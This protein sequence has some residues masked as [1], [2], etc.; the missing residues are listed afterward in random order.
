MWFW[1]SVLFV[2]VASVSP[3]FA[4]PSSDS[5]LRLLWQSN[6]NFA[7]E[8]WKEHKQLF[9]LSKI[10]QTSNFYERHQCQCFGGTFFSPVNKLNRELTTTLQHK[11]TTAKK[12]G[13]CFGNGGGNTP[14]TANTTTP[15]PNPNNQMKDRA[16]EMQKEIKLLLLGSGESGKSTFFKQVKILHNNGFSAEGTLFFN[17]FLQFA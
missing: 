7:I 1:Y 6:K 12:M 11:A 17:K 2:Q 14:S 16:K 10:L 15:Q 4:Q 3:L 8:Y 5:L 13:N 9:V